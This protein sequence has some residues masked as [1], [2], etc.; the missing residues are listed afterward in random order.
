MKKS[1][2]PFLA[3]I[4]SACAV[5]PA[6]VNPPQPGP[7]PPNAVWRVDVVACSLVERA[8]EPCHGPIPGAIIQLHGPDG[9]IA[10]TANA[11]GYAVFTLPAGF[12]DSDVIIDAPGYLTARAHIDVAGTHDSRHNNITLASAHVDPSG[13]PL[14]ELAAIHGAMWTTR[15]NV[16]YGP[17]PGQDTNILAT[18]FYGLYD[19]PTQ[20]RMLDV[21]QG[22]GY[23]HAVAGLV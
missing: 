1:L 20:E 23:T 13:I 21:Y 18:D 17:R 11:A 15:I 3:L 14:E 6:P 5:T 19:A 22:R 12:T 4:F 2:L 9:Y 7:P 10:Q 16:P 8:G